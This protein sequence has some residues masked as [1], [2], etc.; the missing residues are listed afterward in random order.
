MGFYP[1]VVAS[2]LLLSATLRVAGGLFSLFPNW[3][4]MLFDT[5]MFFLS[6]YPGKIGR[7]EGNG[8]R[9]FKAV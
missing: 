9:R 8:N 7:W 2:K 1:I 6:G 3:F 5:E 4:Q